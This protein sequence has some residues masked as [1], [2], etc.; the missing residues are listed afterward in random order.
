MKEFNFMVN[1]TKKDI[2]SLVLFFGV[3]VFFNFFIPVSVLP[4]GVF[5]NI[6]FGSAG[7]AGAAS[8]SGKTRASPPKTTRSMANI[9][10]NPLKPVSANEIWKRPSFET[11][12][13]CS[14]PMFL[15]LNKRI[16]V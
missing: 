13:K 14:S 12:T 10:S 9:K 2:L 6:A 3:L 4:K 5:Y 15:I 16:T 7:G 1:K 11:I 8:C